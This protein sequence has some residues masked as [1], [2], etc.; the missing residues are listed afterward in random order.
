M[1][2]SFSIYHNG[3][4]LE[5][6]ISD[7]DNIVIHLYDRSILQW[8]DNIL[9][10]DAHIQSEFLVCKPMFHIIECRQ[11]ILGFDKAEKQFMI[12]CKS[13]SARMDIHLIIGD[14]IN[15]FC[16]QIIEHVIDSEFIAR[17]S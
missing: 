16:K 13:M 5:F 15:T 17:D 1:S 6:L 4:K 12:F 7:Q 14:E 10:R 3:I 11:E 2:L 8:H 9:F